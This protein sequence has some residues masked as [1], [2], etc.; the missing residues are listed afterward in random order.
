MRHLKKIALLLILGL[1][2]LAAS[3]FALDGMMKKQGGIGHISSAIEAMRLRRAYPAMPPN[4]IEKQAAK[5]NHGALGV[6]ATLQA[7]ATGKPPALAEID[8]ANPGRD[9]RD[10]YIRVAENKDAMLNAQLP[11]DPNAPQPEIKGSFHEL[12]A[13]SRSVQVQST[14]DGRAVIGV[15][16]ET[17]TEDLNAI[18]RINA[19]NIPEH[20]KRRILK[21]YEETGILPEILVKE[22]RKPAA[23]EEPHR[24]KD[25]PYNSKN[26]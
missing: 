10:T 20:M 6:L 2:S 22:T 1:F 14:A 11:E 8:P 9:D 12:G 3:L 15:L 24:E 19:M 25:D 5:A 13:N 26:F 23:S 21:N 4:L 7:A 16:H 17:G 18:D